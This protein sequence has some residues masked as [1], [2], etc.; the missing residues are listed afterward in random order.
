[1]FGYVKKNIL[2]FYLFMQKV[3][4]LFMS[5]YE[6][7]NISFSGMLVFLTRQ[8]NP[9]VRGLWMGTTALAGGLH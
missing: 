9:A 2:K 7:L 3:M 1:V 8:I 5:Q 4:V 6:A